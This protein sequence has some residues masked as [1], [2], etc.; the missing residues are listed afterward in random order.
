MDFR[1]SKPN[2]SLGVGFGE[3]PVV[4]RETASRL[5]AVHIESF[6]LKKGGTT[7]P[8]PLDEG[9]FCI[10]KELRCIVFARLRLE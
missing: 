8:R 6:K 10:E 9:P 7:V 3:N 4:T 2:L 5:D 1:A